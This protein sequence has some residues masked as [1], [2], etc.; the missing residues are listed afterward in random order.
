M[1]KE[2]GK[3]QRFVSAGLVGLFLLVGSAASVRAGATATATITYDGSP[4]GGGTD[5]PNSGAIQAQAAVT[6]AANLAT[7]QADSWTLKSLAALDLLAGQSN[8]AA[9]AI[10]SFA[11]SITIAGSD[12]G[13]ANF[14]F[15]I[16]GTLTRGSDVTLTGLDN[17]QTIE[18]VTWFYESDVVDDYWSFAVPFTPGVPVEFEMD[19]RT[20]ATQ[21]SG[22][23]GPVAS[24]FSSTANLVAIDTD[25]PIA[26]MSGTSGYNYQAFLPEPVSLTAVALAGLLLPRRRQ[27]RAA[28]NCMY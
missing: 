4:S 3:M 5:G 28:R 23:T 11:D 14:T 10:A 24:D 19:L 21:A 8:G 25:V 15:H 7:A 16:D 2:R 18:E 17:G 13:T 26:G 20:R 6:D 12:P 22:G 1:A 27:A 9:T